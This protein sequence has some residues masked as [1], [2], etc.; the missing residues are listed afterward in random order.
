MTG[1][2]DTKNI[3][4]IFCKEVRSRVL[5]GYLRLCQAGNEAEDG[6]WVK[7][8]KFWQHWWI[9]VQDEEQT[10]CVDLPIPRLEAC[11]WLR[12]AVVVLETRHIARNTNGY[13][14][15]S[16]RM[17]FLSL[18]NTSTGSPGGSSEF[19]LEAGHLCCVCTHYVRPNNYY[20]VSITFLLPAISLSVK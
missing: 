7:H 19:G 17:C 15:R 13:S 11:V 16:Q 9:T 1:V 18:M 3:V 6:I 14:A 2:L 10:H 20:Y 5:G 8:R 12:G 4:G